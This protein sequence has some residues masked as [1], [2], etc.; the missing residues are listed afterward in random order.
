MPVFGFPKD[1]LPFLHKQIYDISLAD[2]NEVRHFNTQ[3]ITL[4]LK[5]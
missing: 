4:I 1:D 5:N 2:K 3:I